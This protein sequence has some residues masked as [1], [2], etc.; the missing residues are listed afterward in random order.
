MRG[1]EWRALEFRDHMLDEAGLCMKL[2]DHW[3]SGGEKIIM[4]GEKLHSKSNR[5]RPKRSEA[6]RKGKAGKTENSARTHS[7]KA[8]V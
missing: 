7:S 5:V 6:S 2:S 1:G 3:R 4:W 8:T